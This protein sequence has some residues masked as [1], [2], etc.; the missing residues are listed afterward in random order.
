M[1]EPKLEKLRRISAANSGLCTF[2]C[3]DESG[4][5]HASVI[6]AGV[7][8]HPLTDKPVVAAVVM[9]SARKI[10]M[11]R[12]DPRAAVT[13]RHEWDWVGVRGRAQIIGL[14]DPADGFDIAQL[15]GLLREVF[16]AAGGEHDDW[17]EYDQAMA[18]SRRAAIF[19][20]T[21]KVIS[22]PGSV[23]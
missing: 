12:A 21:D 8:N 2:V 13:F 20:P 22:N 6:N 14:D 1:S 7:M 19:V 9:G 15:P 5:P 10:T 4:A 11:L 3:L 17:D 18:T 23:S 16:Q